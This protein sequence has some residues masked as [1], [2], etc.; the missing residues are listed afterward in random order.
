MGSVSLL[1]L[2]LVYYSHYHY[3]S[4]WRSAQGSCLLIGLLFLAE[5]ELKAYQNVLFRLCCI[6]GH[7]GENSEVEPVG[8]VF[9]DS[10]IKV[11]NN[12]F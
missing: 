5:L 6:N 1:L 9:A 8:I 12:Y 10:E 11:Y 3:F 4:D 2:F 7:G